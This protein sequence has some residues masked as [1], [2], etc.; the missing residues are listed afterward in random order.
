MTFAFC[1][2]PSGARR[3]RNLGEP[4]C[5]ECLAAASRQRTKDRD[6]PRGRDQ[7]IPQQAPDPAWA[8]Q[9]LC[10]THPNPGLW[11]PPVGKDGNEA[12]AVCALCPVQD[13][14]LTHALEVNERFGIWGGRSQKERIGLRRGMRRG[15]A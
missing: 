10:S 13:Q 7:R 1:G 6:A 12:K 3:H 5:E 15:A 14:C 4:V 2:T 9:G 8:K 11:F